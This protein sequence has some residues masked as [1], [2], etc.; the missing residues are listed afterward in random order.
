MSNYSGFNTENGFDGL[1]GFGVY[2][3]LKKK[4]EANNDEIIQDEEIN[5]AVNDQVDKTSDV[6][7]KIN[8]DMI[9]QEE[10]INA[11]VD[12]NKTND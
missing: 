5:N 2:H 4:P 10:Q 1:T 6:K 9:T 3:H 11:E 7:M 8:K 12:E